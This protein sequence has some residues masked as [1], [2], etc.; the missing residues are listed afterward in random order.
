MEAII[1]SA[2]IEAALKTLTGLVADE[3]KVKSRWV[4]FGQTCRN[5]FVTVQV[6]DQHAIQ[7][8]DA[9]LNGFPKAS[10]KVARAPKSDIKG[11]TPDEVKLRNR[12]SSDI[13]TYYSRVRNLYAFPPAPVVPVADPVRSAHEEAA[14]KAA[15]ASIDKAAAV[16]AENA[17]KMEK[18]QL[19]E[20]LKLTEL[21]L[22]SAVDRKDK[23]EATKTRKRVSDLKR[24][25]QATESKVAEATT[26]TQ[27]MIEAA[28]AAQ[29]EA[30]AK[31]ALIEEQKARE[32]LKS[33]LVDAI[34]V[35]R[36]SKLPNAPDLV[37]ALQ[38][39]HD[40]LVGAAK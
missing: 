12:V 8:R 1:L 2:A 36:E 17:A 37:K 29:L 4:E 27:E 35:A 33:K 22:K 39:A 20:S 38:A 11:M 26:K 9:I 25:V 21:L 3:E 7:I 31:L 32:S 15:Q 14:K 28:K 5:V 40:I 30:N 19:E 16:A 18:K 24:K 23:A 13:S 34:K 6:F 10:Q